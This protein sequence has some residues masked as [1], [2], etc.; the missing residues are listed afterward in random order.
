M[1]KK[2]RLK[3]QRRASTR[4]PEIDRLLG[5]YFT[6]KEA[7]DKGSG[8]AFFRGQPVTSESFPQRF[9]EA[10]E[11]L[12]IPRMELFTALAVEMNT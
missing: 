1:G 12:N 5:D 9:F 7:L 10:G 6:T 11:A 4:S 3:E 2:S 8:I